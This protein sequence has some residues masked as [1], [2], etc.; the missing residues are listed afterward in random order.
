M[1]QAGTTLHHGARA[2]HYRGLSCC[3]AQAPDVQAQ[4]NLHFY[5]INRWDL[6]RNH[7]NIS[8]GM[9]FGDM[10]SYYHVVA[11]CVHTRA[12]FSCWHLPWSRA[13]GQCAGDRCRELF[14][15]DRACQF[16]F[17]SAEKCKVKQPTVPSG[18]SPLLP[19]AGI[20][21]TCHPAPTP[22]FSTTA[23]L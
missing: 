2:S 16:S 7:F 15:S 23:G 19:L 12:H 18:A 3:G 21:E 6:D 1:W 13:C 11:T 17:P 5:T 9:F 10:V 22:A 14:M 8:G 4:Y 20:L